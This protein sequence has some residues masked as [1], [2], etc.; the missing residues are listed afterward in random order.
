MTYLPT[1]A[2][3]ANSGTR[4]LLVLRAIAHL[5]ALAPAKHGQK[6]VGTR[7]RFRDP[8]DVSSYVFRPLKQRRVVIGKI[9]RRGASSSAGQR[10]VTDAPL[11]HET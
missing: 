1:D 4:R 8:S 10:R 2:P 3:R 7:D 11:I 5:A 9:P 6:T